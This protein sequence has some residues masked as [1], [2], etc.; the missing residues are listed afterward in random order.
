[1]WIIPSSYAQVLAELGVEYQQDKDRDPTLLR[2]VIYGPLWASNQAAIS[3]MSGG[4]AV[5][6]LA[7]NS[8]AA[9][10]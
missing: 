10:A 8:P 4:L 3:A 9:F 2:A 7:V 6:C 1:M 5:T